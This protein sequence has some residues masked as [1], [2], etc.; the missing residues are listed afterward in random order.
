[1]RRMGQ[2][3]HSFGS[4]RYTRLAQRKA[5]LR[6]MPATSASTAASCR[7]GG[8]PRPRE[9]AVAAGGKELDRFDENHGS[10]FRTWSGG[11]QR[12]PLAL[13]ERSKY[14]LCPDVEGL[15]E[16][17]GACGQLRWGFQPEH[18]K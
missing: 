13:G 16:R 8:Q 7:R 11:C 1:V 9:S 15:G 2:L 18:A 6:H 10:V 4:S 12:E 14:L 5:W 3:V 17:A